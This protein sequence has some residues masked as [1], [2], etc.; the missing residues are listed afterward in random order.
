MNISVFKIWRSWLKYLSWW[1]YHG[2]LRFG[3]SLFMFFLGDILFLT[4]LSIRLSFCHTSFLFCNSNSIRPSIIKLHRIIWVEKH[5][6]FW[7]QY[8]KGQR[9]NRSRSVLVTEVPF[10]PWITFS[11]VMAVGRTKFLRCFDFMVTILF[12]LFF[13]VS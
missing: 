2:L 1:F 10:N 11:L 12:P 4:C 7:G 13:R 9:E 3:D 6:R 5:C 8:V